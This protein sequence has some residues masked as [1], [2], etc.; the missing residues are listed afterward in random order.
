[1]TWTPEYA[2]S[3]VRH[4]FDRSSPIAQYATVP[5]GV[6]VHPADQ[7]RPVR[8]ARR[9][10]GHGQLPPD[11]R[12]A[13]AV[14]R[15]RRRRRRW[16]RPRRRGWRHGEP[17]GRRRAVTGSVA[18]MSRPAL[19]PLAGSLALL[20]A[21]VACG[22]DDD[23]R[24]RRRRADAASATVDG[25]RPR[26]VAGAGDDRAGP[27]G[28]PPRRASRPSWSSPRSRR[29][30]GRAG[31]RR[32][33]WCSSTTSACAA[34]T[35]PSSTPT[36]AASRSPSRSGAGGVIAGWD[37]GLVGATAGRAAAA[38]HPQRPGLRGRA[39]GRRHPGRRRAVVRHRRARRR[40]ADR[41][42][43]RR[44]PTDL[45]LS[46]ELTTEPEVVDLRR[47]RRRHARGG[48]DRHLPP[49]RRPGRRRHGAADDVGRRPDPADDGREGQVDRR[50]SSTGLPGMKVGGRRLVRVP[51]ER[52][53]RPRRRRPTSS[54]SPTCSRCTEPRP[55]GIGPNKRF[56]ADVEL[57][58]DP[59]ER[60]GRAVRARVPDVAPSGCEPSCAAPERA[61]RPRSSCW[62]AD[63][64]DH[65]GR[66]HGRARALAGLTAPDVAG[67]ER[68][69]RRAD[70]GRSGCAE[71][72]RIR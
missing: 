62:S 53:R 61:P 48:P 46:S 9:P 16:A 39:P 15:R 51:S 65:S 66:R 11:G 49:R 19:A 52:R 29:A 13:V 6:R 2:S 33:H 69:R 35:A 59:D 63:G 41:P 55:V 56:D 3:I 58:Y 10:A 36:S 32:R 22:S 37:Q 31:R 27:G 42:P 28:Q 18:P 67:R 1:M 44:P 30:P 43:S 68:R 64:A 23:G 25:T 20:I 54:S 45:P 34:R 12:G 4:T 21:L 60:L 71:G 50:S 7:P 40:A 5:A 38:R 14:R 24:R 8:A 70:A 47:G 72:V 26:D 17:D 57:V